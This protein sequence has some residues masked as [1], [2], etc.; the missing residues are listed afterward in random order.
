[1]GMCARARPLLPPRRAASAPLSARNAGA[2]GRRLA[3]GVPRHLPAGFRG[4]FG[5]CRH[6]LPAD[7]RATIIDRLCGQMGDRARQMRRRAR[8]SRP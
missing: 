6:R 3:S 5:M 2:R 1:V 4:C 7:P 8:T